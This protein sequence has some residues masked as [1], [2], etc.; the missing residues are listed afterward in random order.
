MHTNIMFYYYEN[1]F[2]KLCS[3]ICIVFFN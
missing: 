2:D 3:C 1:V